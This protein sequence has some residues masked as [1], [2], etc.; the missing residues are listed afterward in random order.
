M[1]ARSGTTHNKTRNKKKKKKKK[2]GRGEGRGRGLFF[3]SSSHFFK[4]KKPTRKTHA[5]NRRLFPSRNINRAEPHTPISSLPKAKNKSKGSRRA[6]AAPPPAAP[7]TERRG[8][9]GG[10]R[11]RGQRGSCTRPPGAGG[12]ACRVRGGRGAPLGEAGGGPRRGL[13]VRAP[14]PVVSESEAPPPW[15]PSPGRSLRGRPPGLRAPPPLRP[16]RGGR[17]CARRRLSTRA[18][19]AG[20]AAGSRC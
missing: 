6:R 11:Q 5:R 18:P 12:P 17:A 4:K 14:P 10:P 3:F 9:G 2:G 20:A 19:G 16:A 8:Q 1:W 15:S 13:R 7:R